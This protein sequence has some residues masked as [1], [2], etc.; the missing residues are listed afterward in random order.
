MVGPE[1]G[2][3][4]PLSYNPRMAST[5][6]AGTTAGHRGGLE[7]PG[8]R[9]DYVGKVRDVYVHPGHPGKALMVA[10][11][12][13]SAFDVVLKETVPDRGRVLTHITEHWLREVEEWMPAARI[14]TRV[15]EVPE[16]PPEFHD[17]LR[18]RS[19]W[20]RLADRVNVEIVLRGRLA[21]SGWREYQRTGRLWEHELPQE[22]FLT[23]LKVD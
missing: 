1:L 15:E 17:A 5:Q 19:T 10:T 4:P 21:G 11:D 8:W 3:V 16:L 22:A 23:V 14:S 20:T 7:I 18:G 13:L 9:L 12:R 2:P 6:E